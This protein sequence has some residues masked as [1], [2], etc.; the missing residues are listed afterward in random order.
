MKKY[1]IVVTFFIVL[2]ACK[3]QTRVTPPVQPPTPTAMTSTAF[4]PQADLP[5]ECD[6]VPITVP[7]LPA[8]IPGYLQV[9]PDTGLHMTGTPTQ[10]DFESYRLTIT[11]LVDHPLSFTY[12][13]LRCLPKITASPS[14]I[15]EGYFV[16]V[17]TWSGVDLKSLLDLAG[18]QKSASQIKIKAAD[19][20][21]IAVPLESALKEGNFLAYEVNGK[22]LPV[23]QGFP[24]RA[25]FPSLNGLYWAKW[26]VGIEVQ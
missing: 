12:E 18:I 22:T 14:L 21:A 11:G 3:T 9:D 20:Y 7:T 6:L 23:L 19:G 13:Q 10:V 5:T 15:C 17:A 16:D 25:V 2:C 24:L 8:K 4:P 26:L 1:L